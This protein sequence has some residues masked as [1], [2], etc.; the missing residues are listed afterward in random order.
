KENRGANVFCL[1]MFAGIQAMQTVKEET[2]EQVEKEDTQT[3]TTSYRAKSS[4]FGRFIGGAI[5]I[6]TIFA[7]LVPIVLADQIVEDISRINNG[8]YFLG[9]AKVAP[10]IS[11]WHHSFIFQMPSNRHDKLKSHNLLIGETNMST[12]SYTKLALESCIRGYE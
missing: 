8:L 6:M 1:H 12:S 10:E 5:K 3:D 7:I 9:V 2:V 4:N 11:S